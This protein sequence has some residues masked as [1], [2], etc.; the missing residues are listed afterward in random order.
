MIEKVADAY[1]TL[2][3][4]LT[5]GTYGREGSARRKRVESTP[6][7]FR[8]DAAQ[9]CDARNLSL[10]LDQRTVPPWILQGRLKDVPFACSPDQLTMPAE[11][12]RGESDLLCRDGVW[13]L[14]VTVRV[15][16]AELLGDQPH[17]GHHDALAVW[18][19]ART[20]RGAVRDVRAAGGAH[21]PWCTRPERR[22]HHGDR[23]AER[24]PTASGPT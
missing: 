10:A 7:E 20:H 14:L 3:S 9:P 11:H 2:T 17:R 16:D 12:K 15:P 13:F 18:R 5:A 24:S 21:P 1:T 19:A 22:A 6:V 23:F 8:P 4:N